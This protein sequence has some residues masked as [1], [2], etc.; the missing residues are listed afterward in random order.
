MLWSGEGTGIWGRSQSEIY[1]I[2]WF[3]PY[4]SGVTHLEIRYGI[5]DVVE[6]MLRLARHVTEPTR[7]DPS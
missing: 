1:R 2:S 5:A 3:R 6:A 4:V 7:L